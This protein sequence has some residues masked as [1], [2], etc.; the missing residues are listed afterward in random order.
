MLP[1]KQRNWEVILTVVG[2][3]IRILLQMLCS[4]FEE[5]FSLMSHRS[6]DLLFFIFFVELSYC[7]PE[8]QRFQT[9][10]RTNR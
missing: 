2:F 5:M 4:S 3:S 9:E 10:R 6:V 7:D 1:K 8:G